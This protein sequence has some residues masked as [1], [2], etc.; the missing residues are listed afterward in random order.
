[1]GLIY[2]KFSLYPTIENNIQLIKHCLI[3]SVSF[4]KTFLSDKIGRLSKNGLI[5]EVGLCLNNCDI[6]DIALNFNS[7]LL[8]L[9]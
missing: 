5:K 4:I 3:P 2:A 8:V 1:M 7:V 9:K 6:V